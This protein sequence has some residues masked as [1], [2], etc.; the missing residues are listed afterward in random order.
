M[1]A[2]QIGTEFSLGAYV[3]EGII[4]DD[5]WLQV[6]LR[7]STYKRAYL[8]SPHTFLLDVGAY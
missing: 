4:R 7:W 6:L 2:V 5:L 1:T 8:M 3:L